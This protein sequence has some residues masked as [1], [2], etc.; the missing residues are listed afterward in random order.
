MEKKSLKEKFILLLYGITGVGIL[1]IVALFILISVG[2]LGF[3]PSF[4]ELENPQTDLATE[5]YSADGEVIGTFFNENRSRV[6]YDEISPNVIRALVSTE[7]IRFYDHSGIDARGLMRVFVR[8]F[9]LQKESSGGGSTI[10]QQLAKLLFHNPAKNI[11]ERSLQKL[12]EWVIALKLERSYTKEE[13]LTMYLNKAPFI[14]DAYGIKSASHTFFSTPPSDLKI[15]EAAVLVGMLKNP[16]LYNPVRRPDLTERRRN[17]VLHQMMKAKLLHPQDFDSLKQIPLELDFKRADHIG[18]L[19]PYFREY[20]RLTISASEPNRESYG[21]WQSE[22]FYEDSIAWI[23]D[24]L[25]GWVNKNLKADG[26][27]YDIY[28]DGLVIHTTIDSHLQKY[29]EEAVVK[30]LGSE[31]QPQFSEEKRGRD[32]APFTQDISQEDYEKIINRSI[33]Q[34]DRYRALKQRKTSTDSIKMIFN[35]PVPMRVFSYHGEVDTIMS[36]LDSIHYYK[37]FLRA[38]L[39]SMDPHTGHVKAYVGGPNYKHFKYDMAT[40]GKRQVGSVIKPFVY[41]LAMQEGLTPCDM[42]PNVSQTF[43]LP[44]GQTWTPRN[45]SSRREGEMV[46]LKWGL[47]QSNN[48]ITAWIIKQYDPKAVVRIMRNMG[49][50]SPIDPVPALALGTPDILLS[51]M[52][53]GYATYAN[54]GVHTEPLFVTHIEDRYG[55]VVGEFRPRKKEAINEENAYLMVNLLEGVVNTGTAYRLRFRYQFTG[56]IGGKTGTTQN[57]SD[58]WFI[59]LTPNLVTG[60]WVGGEERDIHFDNISLG[61]G[62]NMALPIWALYMEPTY[63]D[64]DSGITQEDVFDKPHNFNVNLVCPDEYAP[65]SEGD[66][67]E[68]SNLNYE[69]QN[70]EF[71]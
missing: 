67:E 48:N 17:V 51:E 9:L 45:A 53:A 5:I 14:Y 41:T 29:A 59:G 11:I 12:K 28:R 64:P 35:R 52:V 1:F 46:S 61:Q 31:I 65:T 8:T 24:P 15:E 38:S 37:S 16:S 57:N 34:T 54:K 27:K 30:H 43:Y 69:R 68:E 2:A 66:S 19:A 26:T 7:D 23:S 50:K 71:Y 13:I 25:F 20:L 39:F 18:G 40:M 22:K 49:I 63:K 33:Q 62:A 42:V 47:A 70:R 58:G 60:I 44:T 56:E 6:D 32:R 55:N 10:T 4:E 3:M 21:A 36:P